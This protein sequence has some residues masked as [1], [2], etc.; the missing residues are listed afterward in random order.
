MIP[1]HQADRYYRIIIA[2][3]G[4]F[5]LIYGLIWFPQAEIH[6]GTLFI[7]AI[8]AGLLIQFPTKLLK[9]EVGLVQIVALGGGFILSPSPTAW[10]IAFGMVAG[11]IFRWIV[12]EK[13]SW[14]R[15][16]R[17]NA[18][19]NIGYK[20]GLICIP[21]VISFSLYGH[22]IGTTVAPDFAIWTSG[23][24][25]A[26]TFAVLH[27]GSHLAPY[28]LKW[29]AKKDPKFRSDFGYLLAIELLSIPFILLVVEIYS[30]V[31]WKSLA[32]LGGAAIITAYLL[33]KISN[34]QIEHERR[35]RELSTI[36]NISQSLRSNLDL[37]E[38]LFVIDQQVTQLLEVNNIYVALYDPNTD[39]LWYRLA[40]KYGE[41][42]HWS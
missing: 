23:L 17:I 36:N 25:L 14:R 35:V 22:V 37:E 21:L 26:L 38:L 11:I 8:F 32:L 34:T 10:A 6:W 5:L 19:I 41:R 30:E 13:R 24:I 2:I 33:H 29:S 27:M 16:L 1:L 18:W 3:S 39:K 9:G 7:L 40:V 20:V 31:G 28:F 42:Q 15:L 4:F 12:R